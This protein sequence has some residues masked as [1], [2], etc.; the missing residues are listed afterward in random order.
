[1]LTEWYSCSRPLHSSSGSTLPT[2]APTGSAERGCGSR[3]EPA[4]F[5]SL[6][7]SPISWFHSGPFAKSG[8]RAIRRLTRVT[9]LHGSAPQDPGF[10]LFGGSR[11]LER[12]Y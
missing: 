6:H 10:S 11:G 5:G 3:H 8:E 4:C 12:T 1:M 9:H 7:H 2:L